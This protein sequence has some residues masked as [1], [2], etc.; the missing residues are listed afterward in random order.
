MNLVKSGHPVGPRSCARSPTRSSPEPRGPDARQHAAL[1][2]AAAR[3]PQH[4]PAVPARVLAHAHPGD[5][6][7]ARLRLST[8]R[9]D[10]GADRRSQER[11][12]LRGVRRGACS[13]CHSRRTSVV[14]RGLEPLEEY[15]RTA[16]TSRLGDS[17]RPSARAG[18]GVDD[19]LRKPT[20]PAFRTTPSSSTGRSSAAVIGLDGG[21]TSS[22]AVL[23]D[24][25]EKILKKA[26]TPLE[27]QP[28][29]GHEGDAR[30]PARVGRPPRAR[31]SR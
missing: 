16:A 17:G 19:L 9:A 26:Y 21:S 20:R 2:G 13:A 3:W 4:L 28:D 5:L 18:I 23:I 10:R 8:R 1:E 25:D 15:I 7:R 11:R 27:G 30:R 24:E 12:P 22:K 29:P 31:R 6:G 14:Y